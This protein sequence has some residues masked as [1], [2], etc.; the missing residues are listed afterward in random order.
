MTKILRKTL[1]IASSAAIAAT[2]I[3][4]PITASA[5]VEPLIS[6]DTV[7]KEWKLDFTSADSV[8]GYTHVAKTA[9]PVVG[10]LVTGEETEYGFVGTY[11]DDFNF[12]SRYDS[13]A[14]TKGHTT[15]LEQTANGTG[16]VGSEA[17]TDG[18]DYP[19]RFA[20]YVDNGTYYR[21]R[22]TLTNLEDGKDATDVALYYERKHPVMS[23]ETI[24][25]GEAVTIEFS[26]DVESI[27]FEK[28]DPKGTFTDDMLNIVLAGNNVAFKQMI[29]QQVEPATTLWVLGDST[30]TDGSSSLPFFELNNYTGVGASLSKYVPKDVAVS[31]QGEGGLAAG[32]N[33]HFNIAKN[34]IKAGDYMYVEYGHN[35]KND[36]VAGYLSCLNKYYQACKSPAK[37]GTANGGKATL[38]IVGPIDRHQDSQYTASTNT[39][40]S[41][42]GGYSK[43]GKAYVD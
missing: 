8:A 41:T 38:V 24:R 15:K 25:T 27:Y 33:Y 17:G 31:N 20:M 42:L 19:T 4:V 34:N 5:N 11:D 1:A 21:V 40:S 2:M 9:H 39:W 7:L 14:M 13:L 18:F 12:N 22:A 16:S 6:G 23:H 10:D 28:S 32:D 26:V 36:G 43:A 30:V 29:I 3:A 35:H 37:G